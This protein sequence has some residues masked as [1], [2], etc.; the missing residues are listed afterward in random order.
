[1]VASWLLHSVCALPPSSAT[2]YADTIRHIKLSLVS[3]FHNAQFG[4]YSVLLL[5]I[6]QRFKSVGRET[7]VNC[8][9]LIVF[10]LG[11]SRRVLGNFTKR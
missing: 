5:G 4:Y 8:N 2:L 1:M 10:L 11:G 3:T 9:S 7:Q 6:F